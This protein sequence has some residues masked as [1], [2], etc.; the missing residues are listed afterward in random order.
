ME[1]QGIKIT[2]EEA[3]DL[4]V[5]DLIIEITNGKNLKGIDQTEE[6]MRTV[7]ENNKFI[8]KVNI[9]IFLR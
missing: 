1:G 2:V 8:E 6:K 4:L 7:L 3:K 5:K 9:Y